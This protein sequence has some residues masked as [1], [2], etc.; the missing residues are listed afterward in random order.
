MRTNLKLEDRIKL[1]RRMAESYHEAYA[2]KS[3][4]N[5]ATY[6]E[7]EF[8]D[9]AVYWSPYFGNELIQLSTTPISVSASATMEAKAYSLKFPDW[10]PVEFK[11]WPSDNGFVMK[12]LFAGHTKDGIKMSFYSYGFVETND[13]GQITR[14]E[15]HVSEDYNA[16]LDIAIG[17]HGPFRDS[18]DPYMDALARTLK[19]AGVSLPL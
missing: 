15:T 19:E 8:A 11:C 16:F 2:Q 7:W 12:T 13:H 14:W 4:K 18:P 10:G 3:V 6:E 1:H 5:G 9:D 17:V